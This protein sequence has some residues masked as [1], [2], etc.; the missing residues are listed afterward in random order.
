MFLLSVYTSIKFSTS[1]TYIYFHRDIPTIHLK[2]T[3]VWSNN[4]TVHFCQKFY[5]IA[6]DQSNIDRSIELYLP[7]YNYWPD[8]LKERQ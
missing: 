4:S 3:E 5:E 7:I 8:T 2:M 6:I 1:Y